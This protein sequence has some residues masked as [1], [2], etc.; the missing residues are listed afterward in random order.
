[1]GK[2]NRAIFTALVAENVPDKATREAIFELLDFSQR[3]ALKVL[4][5]KNNKT[6]HYV[7]STFGGSAML[8]YCGSTGDVEMALGNFPQLSSASVIRFVRELGEL[9][10]AFKYIQRFEDK[11]KKGGTQGFLIKETLVDPKIMKV[12]KKCVRELQREIQLQND[13]LQ[14]L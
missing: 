7:V 14:Y 11:R 1:M 5:G 6:F 9:S 8:F 10:P 4:G 2:F 13:T 3:Y 12:F